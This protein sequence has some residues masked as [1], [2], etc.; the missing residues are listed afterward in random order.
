[1]ARIWV[2]VAAPITSPITPIILTTS[3]T[4]LIRRAGFARVSGVIAAIRL[5]I[6]LPFVLTANVHIAVTDSI[7]TTSQRLAPAAVLAK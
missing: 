4:L 7:I 6:I 1:M 3:T 2:G 5:P